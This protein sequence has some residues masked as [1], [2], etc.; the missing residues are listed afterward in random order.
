MPFSNSVQRRITISFINNVN[1]IRVLQTADGRRE[2]GSPRTLNLEIN[3]RN[4][5][6]RGDSFIEIWDGAF[7]ETQ[8]HTLRNSAKTPETGVMMCD[9]RFTICD[10]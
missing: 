2:S 9:L 1:S 7:S 5:E 4:A 6:E 8:R 10:L 3:R